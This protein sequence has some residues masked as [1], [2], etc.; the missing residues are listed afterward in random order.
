[1]PDLQL[2]FDVGHADPAPIEDVLTSLGATSV[3]LEDAGND[4]VLE[5]APGETPL[6][7]TIRIRA[8]FRANADPR[9]IEAGLVA[10]LAAPTPIR[11]ELLEDRPWEREWLRDFHPMRF[12][13]RLWVCP[14]GQAAGD[15]NAICVALDP[16]IAF[17][18]GTHP[19]SALCLEWLVG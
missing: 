10:L 19:T 5:P 3:T 1:M 12:G 8:L 16:G 15:A 6:W 9:A 7:P 18:S 13:G 11:F 4:P 17:G 2:T 14:N